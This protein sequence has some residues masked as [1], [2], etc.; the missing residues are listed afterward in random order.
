MYIYPAWNTINVDL[1]QEG[2]KSDAGTN[3]PEGISAGLTKTY[4]YLIQ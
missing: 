2:T 4:I 1:P 3:L